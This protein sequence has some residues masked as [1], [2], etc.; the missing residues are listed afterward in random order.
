MVRRH[1]LACLAL[2]LAGCSPSIDPEAQRCGALPDIPSYSRCIEIYNARAAAR[3]N[4]DNEDNAAMLLLGATAFSNGYTQ[5]R[6]TLT[7]FTTGIMT[8]CQ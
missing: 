2:A 1:A 7:C 4:S 5:S 8:Q 6:P 3:S